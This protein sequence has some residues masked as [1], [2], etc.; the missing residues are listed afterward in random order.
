MIDA[1]PVFLA[2]ASGLT[3][4]RVDVGTPASCRPPC[5][6]ITSSQPLVADVP[7]GRAPRHQSRLPW[8]GEVSWWARWQLTPLGI[9]AS[10]A[11]R[12]ATLACRR[13]LWSLT[14]STC[15]WFG[16]TRCS[17]TEVGSLYS[18]ETSRSARGRH[19]LD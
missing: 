15:I 2:S 13:E 7:P 18:R 12:P 4:G 17:L 5:G 9:P 11:T 6:Q 1:R 10:L 16:R 19:H 8:W 14:G 3:A